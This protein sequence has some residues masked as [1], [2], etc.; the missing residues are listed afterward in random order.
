MKLQYFVTVLYL[1]ILY[2]SVQWIIFIHIDNKQ[3]LLKPYAKFE[4]K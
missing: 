2:G 1:I 3:S 4:R